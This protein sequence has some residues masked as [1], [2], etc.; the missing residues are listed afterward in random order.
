MKTVYKFCIIGLF[1]T[2]V[3]L[4]QAQKDSLATY[5]LL[6][7]KN[8]P[9][10]IQ[11]YNQYQASLQKVPQVG[12]LPDPQLSLGIFLSPMELVSGK[13]YA[14]IQLMQMFPWFGTL[15][16][17]KDEMSLMAKANYEAM[18]DAKQQTFWNVQQSW[19]ELYKVEQS[20]RISK[21]N[22]DILR[23]VERMALIKFK[24]PT[25]TSYAI[26][27]RPSVTSTATGTSSSSGM[28]TMGGADNATPA[29]ISSGSMNTGGSAMG[30]SS[31]GAGL[32]DL[33]RVKM[34]IGELENNIAS[35]QSKKRSL[36]A[37]FN[38]Y[39]NRQA[40]IPVSIP[41]T[42]SEEPYQM[43]EK[44]TDSLFANNPMLS[45]IRYDN[46]A[47][48]ARKRM[49]RKMGYP[50]IGL[51]VNYSV[52]GKSDEAMNADMNGKDMIMPMINITLPIYRV[53]YKAMRKEA[54]WNQKANDAA[55]VATVNELRTNYYQALEAYED[56]QRRI[57][58]YANQTRL[59]EQTLNLM[60]KNFTASS[61][62][63]TDVLTV[64]QQVLD[65]ELKQND[66]L[67]DYNVAVA[68]VKRILCN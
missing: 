24:A 21:K 17:A 6:A 35:L 12:A 28:Q 41:D 63:L 42:L 47:V 16:A 8:N 67:A 56:A 27:P 36:T 14:N 62:S 50:M 13:Q 2:W 22:L 29:G 4:L 1:S 32:T 3:G 30:S 54:D 19:Y 58:L 33:Y 10:V 40:E 53:K 20:I 34:D 66:A 51:G 7:A 38:A 68:W 9:T 26:T 60:L 15:R 39:L 43:P 65:Y 46:Q 64:R 55:Y 61:T 44:I 25:K 23:S 52:I 11:K 48:D 18:E 59:S 57:K 49:I 37:K 31:G 5:L 45:M